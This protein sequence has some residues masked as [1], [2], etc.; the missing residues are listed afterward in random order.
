MPTE[1]ELAARLGTSRTVVR[2][3]VQILS[4]IGRVRAHKRRGLYVADDDGMLGRRA[5]AGCRI[6][7]QAHATWAY[8]WVRPSRRSRLVATA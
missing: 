4:A 6:S 8:S 7:C 2:E 5:G 1:N 3:A